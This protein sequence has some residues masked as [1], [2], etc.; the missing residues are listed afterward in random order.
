[1]LSRLPQ[2]RPTKVNS[3][4]IENFSLKTFRTHTSK[5]DVLC[6]VI[7]LVNECGWKANHRQDRYLALYYI[8]QNN[9][10]VDQG[11]LLKADRIVVPSKLLRQLMNKARKG[12]P[13]IIRAKIKLPETYCWPS[14]AAHIEETIHHCQG[15][16]DSAKSNP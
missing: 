6:F 11:L 2:P 10:A 4:V 1:M 5:D 13:G 14:I 12:H 3:I 9:L 8:V 7:K 15:C 16:Q